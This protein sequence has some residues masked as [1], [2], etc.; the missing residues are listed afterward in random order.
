MLHRKPALCSVLWWSFQKPQL[1]LMLKWAE[2]L[3]LWVRAGRESFHPC[4]WQETEFPGGGGW[5]LA[6]GVGLLWIELCMS[7]CA[8]VIGYGQRSW[9]RSY[10][11]GLHL[12]WGF[13]S[14]SCWELH[15]GE[16]TCK[17]RNKR[18]CPSKR[19]VSKSA[20]KSWGNRRN[21][22]GKRASFTPCFIPSQN[23]YSPWPR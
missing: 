1:V 8:F 12:R 23:I 2:N 15:L 20:Q 18:A 4:V 5:I 7:V 3:Q 9:A 22:S 11:G 13:H 17:D 10:A 14:R 19:G 16:N 21:P 6:F